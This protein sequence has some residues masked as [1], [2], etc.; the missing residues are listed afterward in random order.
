[1]ALNSIEENRLKNYPKWNEV[2]I[3]NEFKPQ[4]AILTNL[5]SDLDYKKL[6]KILP[7]KV[8]PAYDGLTIDL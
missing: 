5:H 7:R 4:K 2:K 8:F 3:I 1:M 6:K